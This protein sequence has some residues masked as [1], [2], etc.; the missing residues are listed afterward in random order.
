MTTVGVEGTLTA[1]IYA[2]YQSPAFWIQRLGSNWLIYNPNIFVE[3]SIIFEGT[4]KLAFIELILKL[5]FVGLKFTPLDATVAVD[6]QLRE[7]D[8]NTLI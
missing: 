7:R 1:D 3:A 5:S 6:M 2:S 8:S 4:I